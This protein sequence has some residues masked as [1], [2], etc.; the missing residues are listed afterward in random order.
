MS[1]EREVEIGIKRALG[2]NVEREDAPVLVF[3]EILL[4]SVVLGYRLQSWWAWIGSLL[5]ISLLL[6]FRFF[7]FLFS[8]FFCIGWAL[9]GYGLADLFFDHIVPRAVCMLFFGGIAVMAHI[10]AGGFKW[11]TIICPKNQGSNP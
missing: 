5:G 2:I 4:I 3:F 1:I 6:F 7:R 9:F 10:Y 11:I 8:V